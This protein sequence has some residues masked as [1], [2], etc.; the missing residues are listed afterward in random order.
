MK[1]L[2]LLINIV[3][4]YKLNQVVEFIYLIDSLVFF[5]IYFVVTFFIV[6][7]FSHEFILI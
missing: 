7:V 2:V 6:V 1:G 3:A 5:F 4:R